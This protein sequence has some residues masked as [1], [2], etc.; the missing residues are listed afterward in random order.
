MKT[1]LILILTSVFCMPAF[2]CDVQDENATA[3]RSAIQQIE[4][5]KASVGFYLTNAIS[6]V[7]MGTCQVGW[8][9]AIDGPTV[10]RG[11]YPGLEIHF[12]KSIDPKLDQLNFNG[13]TVAKLFATALALGSPNFENEPPSSIKTWVKDC[14]GNWKKVEVPA[15]VILDK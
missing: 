6:E 10:V 8:V 4:Y 7:K 5:T 3:V 1:I 12:K 15:C 11:S 9:T 2:A 13:R 14:K